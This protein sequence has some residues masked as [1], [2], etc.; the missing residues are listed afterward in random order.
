MDDLRRD[1][2]SA[3]GRK[4]RDRIGQRKYRWLI[5]LC[6]AGLVIGLFA[7]YVS[8]Y[9]HADDTALNALRSDD[10]VIVAQTEFGWMFDGPSKRAALIFYPGA[11]VEETAY[12]PFLHRLAE[13]GID[14][15]LVKMPF[16]LAVFGT[17]RADRLLP[18]FS[19]ES[20]YI[21]GHL[22]GGA[23]AAN[24][25]SAHGA[26]LDG[27]ILCAAY[28]IKSLDSGL[29]EIML[30]GSED[31]VLRMNKVAESRQYAPNHFIERVIPGG[32]H[33][34]FGNYGLQA[35]DGTA[36]ISSEEQQEQA[37]DVI[38]NEIG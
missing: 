15:F 21:G 14:V 7:V 8:D 22:L 37:A 3:G 20:W 32:N 31:T 28:P 10:S 33:A 24:Y 2:F 17:N 12:A 19:Y 25:A 4:G 9:Y 23:M 5:P 27:V 34:Q 11:K 35:G 36:T 38:L 26:R 29:T 18:R 1:S 6:I 16:H 13:G 30:Y